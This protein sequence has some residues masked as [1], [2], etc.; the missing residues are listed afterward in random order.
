MNYKIKIMELKWCKDIKEVEL[1]CIDLYNAEKVKHKE[2]MS[3][4]F[5]RANDKEIFPDDLF[6]DENYV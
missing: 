6:K 3:D 2:L 4:L 5:K 1:I